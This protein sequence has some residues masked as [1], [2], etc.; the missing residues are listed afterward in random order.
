[1]NNG[2]EIQSQKS[3]LWSFVFSFLGSVILAAIVI[4]AIAW[5]AWKFF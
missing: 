3:M 4:G 2:N 1:M 5:T